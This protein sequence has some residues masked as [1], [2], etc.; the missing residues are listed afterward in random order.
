MPLMRFLLINGPNLN[1]LGKREPE[2]YG[3]ETLFDIV[4]RVE[5]RA[6]E[7]GASIIPFQSNHEGAIID[8]MQERAG[9]AT[10]IIINAASL[11]HTSVAIRDAIVASGLPAV[12]VHIS[13]VFS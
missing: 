12:E 5:Q 6:S 7:L 8:F 10:G 2:I 3:R 11:T 9:E 1:T 4:G 13:N